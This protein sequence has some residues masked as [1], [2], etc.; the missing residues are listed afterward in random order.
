MSL[1]L[2]DQLSKQPVPPPPP[3]FGRKVHR[4]LN[5]WLLFGQL[6][7]L[8]LRGIPFAALHFMRA[9]AAGVMF[10]LTGRNNDRQS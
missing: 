7:D 8:T 10:T 4:R 6:A 3:D 2:L 9:L 5:G 1:N